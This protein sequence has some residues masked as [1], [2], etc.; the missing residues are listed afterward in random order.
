M[1]K[2]AI[3]GAHSGIGQ[4]LITCLYDQNVSIIALVTPWSTQDG[5]VQHECVTYL[6]C[7]LSQ[8][9]PDEQ[10]LLLEDCDILVHLAWARPKKV[11]NAL[12]DNLALYD[13]I[14]AALPDEV[15]TVFMSS[16]CA[17]P[18]NPSCYGQAKYGLA[19]RLD[20]SKTV[21]IIAGLVR[22]TPAMGPYLALE[23]FVCKL[24]ASFKFL[25]SP[26]AI[27]ADGDQVMAALEKAVLDFDNCG[28]FIKAYDP[29]PI[30]LN[31]LI[32]QILQDKQVTGFPI[33]VPAGLTV[34]GLK[35]VR[36]ILPTVSISDR[37]IT[38]LT[39][40]PDDLNQ[41]FKD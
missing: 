18:N 10:A 37:L 27:V 2:V 20:R 4:D 3:T 22:T 5:L 21:E 7:D 14:K 9:I 29:V 16:V 23:N 39:V 35:L 19:K 12:A 25:P 33:P 32:V 38:L 40:S 30:R 6:A 36:K 41:R 31:D 11:I 28:R 26:Q 13:N 8:T 24:H 1:L 34:W 15:K 17:T